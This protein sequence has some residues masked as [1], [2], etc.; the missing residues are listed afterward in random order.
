MALQG[1]V[2][3]DDTSK[4]I[5][6]VAVL[7]GS[8]KSCSS[9]DFHGGDLVALMGGCEVDLRQASIEVDQ[10]VL[11]AYALMGGIEIYVPADWTVTCKV[12]P[13]LGGVKEKTATP[14]SDQS[15]NLLI[16]GFAIMG[17]IEIHN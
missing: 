2:R 8:E 17:G 15:K 11:N 5:S 4:T 9:P 1:R 14:Q 16:R 6:G 12:F 13:F 7:G 10:A 3:T